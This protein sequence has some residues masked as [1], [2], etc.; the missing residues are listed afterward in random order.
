MIL[1][2][3]LFTIFVLACGVAFA[4]ALALE[5]KQDQRQ[6]FMARINED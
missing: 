4:I 5:D 6:N 1:F 3:I 2:G